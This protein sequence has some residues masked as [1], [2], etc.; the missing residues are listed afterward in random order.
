MAK[1]VLRVM[2]RVVA[3]AAGLARTYAFA[4]AQ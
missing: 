1:G 3:L 2:G 4:F